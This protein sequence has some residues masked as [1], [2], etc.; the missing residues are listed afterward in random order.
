MVFLK[1]KLRGLIMGVFLRET[2]VPR[3]I[4]E[5]FGFFSRAENLERITPP[6]LRFRIV[7][8]QPIEL[9]QGA[10]IAYRMRV[11]G[12]PVRWVSEIELWDPPFEFRDVQLRG[13]YKVWRHT[14][15]FSEVEGGTRMTDAVNYDVGFG[16]L[17][18]LIQWLQVARDIRNIFDYRE[19]R[20]RALLG[21]AAK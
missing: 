15:R 17:G 21:G 3:P 14:H 9:R 6:W 11:H 16:P 5:V 4:G 18:R 2:L 10:T 12:V 1:I 19:Q 13:P 20:V 7:T 8:P